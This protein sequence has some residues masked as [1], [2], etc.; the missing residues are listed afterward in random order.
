MPYYQRQ[1][2]SFLDFIFD[3]SRLVT[4]TRFTRFLCFIT[5]RLFYRFT[6]KYNACFLWAMKIVRFRGCLAPVTFIFQ[7]HHKPTTINLDEYLSLFLISFNILKI[8]SICYQ[9]LRFHI[10][11]TLLL[12]RRYCRFF[13]FLVPLVPFVLRLIIL[14]YHFLRGPISMFCTFAFCQLSLFWWLGWISL[15][16]RKS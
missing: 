15:S 6:S 12:N 11:S 7:Y 5:A 3:L 13:F 2:G 10:S 16:N 1:Y 14:L 4:I 8:A 9:S